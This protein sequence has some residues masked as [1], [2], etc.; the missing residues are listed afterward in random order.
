MK[1][2][3][4]EEKLKEVEDKLDFTIHI[5]LNERIKELINV[6]MFTVNEIRT[7]YESLK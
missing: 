1:E 6:G 7:L 2:K 5:T 4:D 3:T